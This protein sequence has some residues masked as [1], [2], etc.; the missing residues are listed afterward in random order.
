M[1]TSVRSAGSSDKLGLLGVVWVFCV[2]VLVVA[3]A[4]P[5]SAAPSEPLLFQGVVRVNAVDRLAT[6]VVAEHLAERKENVVMGPALSDAEQR[7]RRA[8]CLWT[9]A[10]ARKAELVLS[11]DV[12]EVV[13]AKN[14]LRVLLHLYDAR[15]R[16]VL[17]QENL[18]SDCDETKLGILLTAT[19]SDLLLR[20]RK[21]AAATDQ[22]NSLL[23]TLEKDKKAAQ[24]AA[25]KNPAPL[26][27]A[28]P[29][30]TAPGV[31]PMTPG[32][33]PMPGAVQAPMQNAQNV[34]NTQGPDSAAPQQ[35]P[36]QTPY[37]AP[38]PPPPMVPITNAGPQAQAQDKSEPRRG[39]STRRKAI[40]GVF[41]ALGAGALITSIVLTGLDK[42]LD[43][44]LA[45]NPSGAPCQSPEYAG[46]SCVISMTRIWGPGYG[47]SALLLGGMIL[48][49]TL[50]EGKN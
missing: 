41:G 27:E 8:Q 16:E 25:A 35:A 30:P 4:G 3:G 15:R 6:Q 32:V 31:L 44:S 7:C 50:P 26:P 45:Y 2:G 23:D 24:D 33:L 36:W 38:L 28:A 22:V 12:S 42:R 21:A 34:Q 13:G 39:L 5:A 10:S 48:T 17:D 49:L 9:L 18:C 43:P 20:Y 37:P 40:A 29:L 19:T 14:T 1:R 47:L 46:R 11:G